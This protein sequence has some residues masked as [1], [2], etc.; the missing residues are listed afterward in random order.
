MNKNPLS[1]EHANEVPASCPCQH[2]CYCYDNTCVARES[3][4]NTNNRHSNDF[5]VGF[6]EGFANFHLTEEQYK[7]ACD[8]IEILRKSYNE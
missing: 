2:D 3:N 1:C 6:V 7:K 4:P 8:A 5:W